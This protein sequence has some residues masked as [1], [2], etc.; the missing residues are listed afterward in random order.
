MDAAQHILQTIT[1]A[2]AAGIAMQVF[3]QKLRLP[4]IAFLMFAG[5]LLGPQFLD[6]VDPLSLGYFL[7][8]D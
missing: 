6:L 7:R 5:I 2:V 4:S 1:I 3:S 8:V